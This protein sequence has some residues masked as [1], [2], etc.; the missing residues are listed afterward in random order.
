MPIY[1]DLRDQMHPGVAKTVPDTPEA[2]AILQRDYVK[3]LAF[4]GFVT[5]LVETGSVQVGTMDEIRASV[6]GMLD[7]KPE[8][9]DARLADPN[10]IDSSTAHDWA[11]EYRIRAKDG[12]IETAT[13]EAKGHLAEALAGAEGK[14]EGE[15][16]RI[17]AEHR[18]W[19]EGKRNTIQEHENEGRKVLAIR[20]QL[21]L[22]HHLLPELERLEASSYA[23]RVSE[24]MDVLRANEW[25]NEHGED[26]ALNVVGNFQGISEYIKDAVIYEHDLQDLFLGRCEDPRILE[27]A[28]Q[29]WLPESEMRLLA[30]MYAQSYYGRL[31]AGEETPGQE[32]LETLPNPIEETL[33]VSEEEKEAFFIAFPLANGQRPR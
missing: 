24:L 10:L 1:G 22:D 27:A 26:F 28:Q 30:R 25:F 29:T 7:I 17:V 13:E 18:T 6:C 8:E 23:I 19:I 16:E 2:T 14:D 4:G 3:P 20:D 15:L 9:F 5:R 12:L 31:P 11:A 32:E 21:M 33:F